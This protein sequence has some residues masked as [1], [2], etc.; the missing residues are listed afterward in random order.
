MNKIRTLVVDDEPA[1]RRGIVLLLE[2][3]PDILIVGEAS[4]GAEAVQKIQSERADLV[5]LDVQMPEMNGFKVLEAL[6]ARGAQRPAVIFVTAFD[7]H[8]L[9]A[10]EVNAVDYLLKPFEDE[11]FWAALRRAKSELVR[12]QTDA[13]SEKLSDLLHHLQ[14]N[15]PTAVPAAPAAAAATAASVSA[16]QSGAQESIT[17]ERILLRSGGEIYFVK[18]EDI[19]WIEAEG[20]Y[21]KFHAGG[22]VHMLRETMAHLEERLDSRRFI[23]IH[24]STIVNIDRVKKLSPSFAGEYAVILHDGTKLRLSRG[25]HDRLQDLMRSA[26]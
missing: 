6:D 5:F 26:L 3:D 12:R 8:A 9:R 10:F 22:R 23:R 1:A 20:D 17:R 16:E 4:S 24:R 2:R 14:T 15:V 21:M 13:L 7:Q 18:A 25:Y 19:D 11:R